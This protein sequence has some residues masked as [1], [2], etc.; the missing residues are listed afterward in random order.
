MQ[1][2]VDNGVKAMTNTALTPRPCIGADT[3]TIVLNVDNL[4]GCDY[5]QVAEL[6]QHD[7]V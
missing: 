1:E 3:A 5:V 2:Y 6:S 4:T 7:D